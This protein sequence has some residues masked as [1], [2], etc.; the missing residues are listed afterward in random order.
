MELNKSKIV[1]KC[2]GCKRITD[3]FCS[4]YSNPESKWKSI[5]CCPMYT[6]IKRVVKEEHKQNPIK[7]SKAKSKK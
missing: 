6:E 7:A 3:E 1:E 4:I 2:V 5:G